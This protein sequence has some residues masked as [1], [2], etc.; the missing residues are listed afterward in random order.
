MDN[1]QAG[2]MSRVAARPISYSE[3]LFPNKVMISGFQPKTR[4][5]S[6]SALRPSPQM[7]NRGFE[8]FDRDIRSQADPVA[9]LL[10]EEH[11]EKKA[12]TR[13]KMDMHHK[14]QKSELEQYFYNEN[15]KRKNEAHQALMDKAMKQLQESGLNQ[16]VEVVRAQI[17]NR[18]AEQHINRVMSQPRTHEAPDITHAEVTGQHFDAPVQEPDNESRQRDLPYLLL[19]EG[20]NMRRALG[21]YP[22]TERTTDADQREQQSFDPN[23]AI[24]TNIASWYGS[25]KTSGGMAPVRNNEELE[26]DV[27]DRVL[28]PSAQM[29]GQ[30]LQSASRATTNPALGLDVPAQAG[31]AINFKPRTTEENINILRHERN[32]SRHSRAG[33]KKYG[34]HSIYG[35]TEVPTPELFPNGPAA[36]K[37]PQLK[38][39]YAEK[40]PSSKHIVPPTVFNRKSKREKVRI[41]EEMGY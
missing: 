33:F 32:P 10:V 14:K 23:V 5:N 1:L 30:I 22:T 35:I 38:K 37:D 4:E 39:I 34:G 13:I 12:L 8:F 18:L 26:M 7:E 9:R 15:I 17:E 25:M 2:S 6:Y 36:M 28:L 3:H 16:P 27:F 41:L 24:P 20:M 11:E 40:I 31:I 21:G 29:Q 19:E